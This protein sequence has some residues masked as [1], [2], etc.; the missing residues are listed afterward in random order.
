MDGALEVVG[1]WLARAIR[2]EPPGLSR[3]ADPVAGSTKDA[4]VDDQGRIRQHRPRAGVAGIADHLELRIPR[5]H[6]DRWRAGRGW[7]AVVARPAVKTEGLGQRNV[8]ILRRKGDA[9]DVVGVSPE[10]LHAVTG[11]EVQRRPGEHLVD[12]DVVVG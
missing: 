10:V 11:S 4:R 8:G 1:T 6:T 3:R 12:S 7:D 5:L 9:V 2:R